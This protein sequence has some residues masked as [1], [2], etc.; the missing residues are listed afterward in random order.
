[1]HD[2][3]IFSFVSST[4]PHARVDPSGVWDSGGLGCSVVVKS[5]GPKAGAT[6]RDS[7]TSKVRVWDSGGLECS[8]EDK[9]K[10][11][12]VG[13]TWQHF[14]S[15]ELWEFGTLGDLGC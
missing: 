1:M 12:K 14:G 9:P 11:L 5:K 2:P 4:S 10:G 7:W 6:W 8:V 13:A 15:S 3:L